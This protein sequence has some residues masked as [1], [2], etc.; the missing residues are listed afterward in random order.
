MLVSLPQIAKLFDHALLHP[1]QT[2]A[3]IHAVLLLA[4]KYGVAAV[5]VKPY[6]VPVA[7]KALEGSDVLVCA[8]VGF[9]HG[10]CTTST[11]VFEAEEAINYGACEIDMVV[12]VGKVLGGD[13]DYVT[14]EIQAVNKSVVNKGARLKVIFENDFLADEHIVRL[15]KICVE[16]SVAFVKTSTGFG[17]VKM[18][19]GFHASRGATIPHLKLMLANVSPKVGVKAAGGIRTLDEVLHMMSLGVAR[20]GMSS[21]AAI[22]EEAARRGIGQDPVEVEVSD[23]TDTLGGGSY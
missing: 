5:C 4:K 11:K 7:T 20:I 1:T 21:T 22:L 13:W 3:E 2:D 8:V 18:S 15:C 9:P 19:N 12:N 23:M 6:S 10:S 17:F 16:A 14:D